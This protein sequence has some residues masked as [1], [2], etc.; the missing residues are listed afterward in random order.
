ML[1]DTA[2]TVGAAG[3]T[4]CSFVL[5]V[6]FTVTAMVSEPPLPSTTLTVTAWLV[7]AS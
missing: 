6:T 2:A 4:G 1:P 3:L 7:F 5:L